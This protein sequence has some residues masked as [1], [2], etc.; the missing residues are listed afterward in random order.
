MKN[1]GILK[2][3]LNRMAKDFKLNILIFFQKG[4]WLR[5]GNFS[6]IEN[7]NLFSCL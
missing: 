1:V 6:T 3:E 5:N 4:I 7:A 2:I